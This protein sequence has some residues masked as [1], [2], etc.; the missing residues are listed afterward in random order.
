[1][2]YWLPPR[3][4]LLAASLESVGL[5]GAHMI[6][7]LQGSYGV[8]MGADLQDCSLLSGPIFTESNYRPS[9]KQH[10]YIPQSYS[11]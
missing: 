7:T 5:V 4:H 8:C 10:A 6:H 9:Y 2:P 3:H 11:S 1:M